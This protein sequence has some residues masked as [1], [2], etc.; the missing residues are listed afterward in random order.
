[1]ARKSS[2]ITS[3][4]YASL[5][6]SVRHS[7]KEGMQTAEAAVQRQRVLTYWQIGRDIN[8]YLKGY[9]GPYLSVFQS[10]AR[11][12][13]LNPDLV[14]KIHK[15]YTCFP[16]L[17]KRPRLSWSQYRALLTAPEA[18]RARLAARAAQEGIGSDA[19]YVLIS[20]L[21]RQDRVLPKAAKRLTSKRGRLYVYKTLQSAHLGL[22]ADEIMIDCGFQ[23]K[24]KLSGMKSSMT[25]GNMVRA[26]K[27]QNGYTL[28]YAYGNPAYLYT[29]VARVR[30]VVDGDTLALTIDAGFDMWFDL[31]VRLLGINTPELKSATGKIARQYVARVLSTVDFVVIKTYRQGK[32][33]RYL[34]DVYYLPQEPDPSV[35]AAKGL[36][37]NQE[38]LDQGVAE[39]FIN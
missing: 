19:L 9:S 32:Y 11:D 16:K 33:G 14:R 31:N 20:E 3:V 17:S 27:I 22:T 1:M 26:V 39:D 28:K 23:L 13:A 12:I 34:A 25:G 15:F 10:I 6:A 7:L 35:V 38:L 8:A 18:D 21:R 24:R 4:S 2:A 30:R 5:I 36:F 29:Y 37:L